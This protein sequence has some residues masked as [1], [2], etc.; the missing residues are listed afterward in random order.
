MTAYQENSHPSGYASNVMSRRNRTSQKNRMNNKLI[1]RR[2]NDKNSMQRKNIDINDRFIFQR[3]A[4]NAP[5]EKVQATQLFQ[6]QG[7][8]IKR[9]FNSTKDT[10][11]DQKCTP[12]HVIYGKQNYTEINHS[13]FFN[14]PGSPKQVVQQIYT[15]SLKRPQYKG[16]TKTNRRIMALYPSPY[17]SKNA[18]FK[19]FRK[20]NPGVQKNMFDIGSPVKLRVNILPNLV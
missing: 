3:P 11:E 9:P 8:Q 2:N 16:N 20:A 13:R 14:Y 17:Q 15:Q 6:G 7:S 18:K 19:S 10:I 4:S 12:A 5:V 1:Y